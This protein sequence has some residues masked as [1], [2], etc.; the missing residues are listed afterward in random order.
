M[1][2]GPVVLQDEIIRLGTVR[3][4]CM[5]KEGEREDAFQECMVKERE[6]EQALQ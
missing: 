3:A 4:T 1:G 6:W 5:V 2:K